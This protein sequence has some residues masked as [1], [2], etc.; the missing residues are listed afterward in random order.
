MLHKL[1]I[2]IAVLALATMACGFN[3]E[4]PKRAQPG[5]EVVKEISL[6]YPKADDVSLKLSF[7]AGEM[8]LSPGGSQLV[9]GTATYNYKELK[10]QVVTEGGDVQIKMGDEKFTV[11]PSSDNLKNEWDLKLGDQ[12]MNLNIE[13]GAYEGTFE[14]GG[15]ALTSLTIKDGAAD[16]KLVFSEP[17]QTEMSVFKYSTGASDVKM[18][19]LANANFSIFDFSSGAGDYILDFSGELQRDASIKIVSG[20]SNLIIIVPEGVDAVVTVQSG[21]S[22][23]NAGSGWSQS[24]NVYKQ[25]GEGSTLTFVVEMGAGN[26]TLSK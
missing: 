4:L 7:G 9:D 8:K 26:L 2:F 16:V 19:G 18:E 5:P 24:G 3:I 14:F 20:F 13:A 12:P 10:P 25:K 17:N 23:I 21:I 22:N 6:P 1:I 15:L 11:F